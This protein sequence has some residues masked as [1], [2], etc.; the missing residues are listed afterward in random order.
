MSLRYDPRER[1]IQT[2]RELLE[3]AYEVVGSA[4]ADET[5]MQVA[6]LNGLTAIEMAN[7]LGL[8]PPGP[9]EKDRTHTRLSEAL[10]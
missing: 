9:G 6:I 1:V 7:R 8:V 10:S 4:A 2:A 3:L 5:A